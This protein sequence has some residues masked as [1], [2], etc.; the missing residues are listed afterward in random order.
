[1]HSSLSERLSLGTGS[2]SMMHGGYSHA[3]KGRVREKL[4]RIDELTD[5]IAYF[6]FVFYLFPIRQKTGWRIIFFVLDQ[7]IGKLILFFLDKM[8]L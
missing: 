2:Q 5:F 7:K 3:M 4:Q 8:K 1:M 6:Q